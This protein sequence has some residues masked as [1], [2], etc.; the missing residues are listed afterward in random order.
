MIVEI[1]QNGVERARCDRQNVG[2]VERLNHFDHVAQA[3]LGCPVVP[4]LFG[5]FEFLGKLDVLRIDLARRADDA[6]EQLGGIAAGGPEIGHLH[7]GLDPEKSH[8]LRRMARRVAL[9]V[10]GGPLR[11]IDR[12][13]DILRQRRI[14]DGALMRDLIGER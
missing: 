13:D 14:G 10:G 9:L 3:G 5:A 1:D 4:G 7:P 2:G 6:R 12:G 11:R 8:H